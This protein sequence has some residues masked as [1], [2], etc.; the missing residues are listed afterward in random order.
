MKETGVKIHVPPPAVYSNE[1]IISGD[2]DGV[3]LA[4]KKINKIYKKMV[5][6]NIKLNLCLLFNCMIKM[7]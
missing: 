2:K 7:T 4:I 1:I 5:C 3:Q 6:K